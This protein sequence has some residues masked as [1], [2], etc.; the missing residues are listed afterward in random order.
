MEEVEFYRGPARDRRISEIKI[1]DTYVRVVGVVV[2][3]G[4]SELVLDD[5]SGH[6]SVFF[7]DPSIISGLDVG[8]KVRV[9]G[10][11]HRVGEAHELHADI[12]QRMDGL[13]LE[14]HEQVRR[15]LKKFEME[16][17]QTMG[18]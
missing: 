2:E 12:V 13:D 15:E 18:R 4:E 14:L 6:L 9:F 3:K 5:G 17:E 8:C 11:P 7:D 10:A 1:C 16:M